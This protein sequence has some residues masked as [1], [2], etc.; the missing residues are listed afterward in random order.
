MIHVS[1]IN[2]TMWFPVVKIYYLGYLISLGIPTPRLK[3][4][5][6][7]WMARKFSNKNENKK[8]T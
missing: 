7:K 6:I 8:S 4:S 5:H 2:I 3:F 1:E